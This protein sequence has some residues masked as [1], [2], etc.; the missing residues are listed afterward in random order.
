MR[1]HKKVYMSGYMFFYFKFLF[2]P[3]G[4]LEGLKHVGC[5]Q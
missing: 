5:V 3:G 2:K 1:S 4:G